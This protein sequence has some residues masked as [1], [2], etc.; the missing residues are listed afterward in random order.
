MTKQ[1]RAMTCGD[2]FESF[3]L[4]Q[5]IV[6][7]LRADVRPEEWVSWG[8]YRRNMTVEGIFGEF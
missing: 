4:S 3:L 8:S 5:D 1:S 2:F 6:A 7:S